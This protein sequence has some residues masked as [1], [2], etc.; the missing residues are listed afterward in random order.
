MWALALAALVVTAGHEVPRLR[1]GASRDVGRLRAAREPK[2]ASA[3]RGPATRARPRPARVDPKLQAELD[4][5]EA[6][7]EDFRRRCAE[8]AGAC[9]GEQ[10]VAERS[11]ALEAERAAA[12][13]AL[14]QR[15]EALERR[16]AELKARE[17]ALAEEEAQKKQQRE[18]Q[19]KALERQSQQNA[20]TV[21]G[22][23]DALGD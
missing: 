3:P 14:K 8:N 19:R 22:I 4:A 18:R 5:A 13:A 7:A 11:R 6:R 9:G 2:P 1:G 12:E 16:E 15:Q 10:A 17:E 23:L 20:A 21:D